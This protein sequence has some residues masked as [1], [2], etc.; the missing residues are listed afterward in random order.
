[1]PNLKDIERLGKNRVDFVERLTAWLADQVEKLQSW[2]Y[3]AFFEDVTGQI[4]IKGGL[5]QGTGSINRINT[6]PV[7]R[8][9]YK[10]A[11]LLGKE[12]VERMKQLSDLTGAYMNEVTG[13]D[14]LTD[15]QKATVQILNALGYDGKAFIKGGFFHN[16]INDVTAERRVK[17][18]A[19]EAINSGKSL[20]DF[21]KSLK[22]LIRG[23]KAAGRLGVVSSHYYTN[24]N[25]LYAEFDRA[26]NNIQAERYELTHMIW[27]G[28]FVKGTR[29][30]CADKKGK[31]FTREQV[32]AMDK[33]TWQGKIPGQSTLISMGGRNCVDI[34]L[35]ITGELAEEKEKT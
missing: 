31:I 16:L 26:L 32:I 33:Q 35:W 18:L 24:A 20:S 10:R 4:V 2:L 25:T 5:K 7:W 12:M 22:G 19:I 14:T 1:M 28:P 6:S 11:E 30:F 15:N 23:D 27:S 17:R 29:K 9:F 21:Q 13:L 8:V 34:G 3:D